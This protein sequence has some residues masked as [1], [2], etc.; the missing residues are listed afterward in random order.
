MLFFNVGY[1]YVC[2]NI[3]FNRAAGLLFLTVICLIYLMLSLNH[4]R[5]GRPKRNQCQIYLICL[6]TAF[7]LALLLHHFFILYSITFMS[8]YI[9]GHGTE[10]IPVSRISIFTKQ[11]TAKHCFI[12]FL[13]DSS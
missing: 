9:R 3:C 4:A 10:T 13:D 12:Y 8:F 1:L 5:V 7:G 2:F 6:K 11:K